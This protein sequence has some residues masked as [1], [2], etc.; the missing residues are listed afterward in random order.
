MKKCISILLFIIMM[1]GCSS[2]NSTDFSGQGKSIVLTQSE[3]EWIREHPFILCAPDPDFPPAEFFNA[4]GEY[5]GLVAD[6]LGLILKRMG[7]EPKIVKLEGWSEVLTHAREKKIDLVTAASKTSQ[8]Q[9][10][11]D[12]TEPFVELPAVIIARQQVDRELTLEKLKGMK[13]AVVREYAAHDYIVL[14]Y[15]YLDLDIVPDIQTGLRKVSFGIVDAMVVNIASAS[16]YIEKGTITNLK[17]AGESGFTY[18]LCFAPRKDW[19][20]LTRILNKGLASLSS[21][22][23]YE[24]YS[25]WIR[26][27]RSP[28]F[29]KKILIFLIGFIGVIFLLIAMVIGWNRSLRA[30]VEEKTKELKKEVVKH[31]QAKQTITESENRYRGMFEHT[32][33]GVIIYKA[34]KDGKDFIV[35]DSNKSAKRIDQ[36]ENKEIIGKSILNVFPGIQNFG[37][38][39]IFQKVW[40]TGVPGHFPSAFYKD[41]RIQGWRD[42]FVYKLPSNEI[43]TVYSDE[44]DRIVAEKALRE[45]EEKLAGIINSTNDHMVMLDEELNI[46][47]ANHTSKNAFGDDLENKKCYEAFAGLHQ[48]CDGCVAEKCFR[49]GHMQEREINLKKENGLRYDFWETTNAVSLNQKGLPKTIVT[50]FRDITQR[51]ALAAEAMR[52]GHLASIGE[53]AAGVAHEIN[54]PINSVINLA[55]LILNENKKKGE[56]NDIALRMIN[57]G[58]RI[59][60]IVS[61]LLSFAKDKKGSKMELNIK[62]VL[63][64]T[65]ALTEA[66]IVKSGIILDVD[67]P[68][69]L[70]M[71]FGHMQQIQQVFLNLINNARFALNHKSFT[72]ESLKTIKIKGCVEKVMKHTYLRI[73]FEDNGPGIPDRLIDRVMDPFFTTKP[74]GQGT[75]LGL[76]ISHGIISGHKGKMKIES[77]EGEFTRV[78]IDF[79]ME[80]R[81]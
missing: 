62:D 46:L 41:N 58:S 5:K 36:L 34:V 42:Y 69:D 25:K 26:L 74:G 8:R 67:L 56:Q 22:E 80:G 13:V 65:F 30:V 32:K 38:I 33:S 23:K 29:S 10:F 47:W 73:V 39:T 72:K 76:S 35:L 37:L 1:A 63:A 81:S 70:P 51:K 55:Q 75:G 40:K 53:L 54:N 60:D 6:Y 21:D 44:T 18:K 31:E 2:Q 9:I 77:L 45:S 64:E 48:P 12:F 27:E 61:S 68:S 3:Q 20:V 4:S 17:V 66:Q 71:I 43:V 24:I 28:I 57:E 79:P 59:A 49:E 7:L 78:I 52:A 50:I 16:Y 19:P 14:N 15:P 11:L